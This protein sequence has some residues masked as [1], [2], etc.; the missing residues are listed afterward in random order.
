M[1]EASR[2]GSWHTKS[3]YPVGMTRRWA[4]L[5]AAPS[6]VDSLSRFLVRPSRQ[7]VREGTATEDVAWKKTNANNAGRSKVV[8]AAAK[9][10]CRLQVQRSTGASSWQDWRARSPRLVSVGRQ[11]LSRKAPRQSPIESTSTT[12]CR[13]RAMSQPRLQQISAM[14]QCENGLPKARSP[15]WTRPASR[16]R[17]SR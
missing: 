17:C 4:L 6:E 2:L 10:W 1:L 7:E 14:V 9:K 11:Q 12:I 15:T 3:R 13:R 16:W 8:C 5:S